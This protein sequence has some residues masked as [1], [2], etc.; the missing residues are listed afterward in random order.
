MNAPETLIVIPVVIVILYIYRN[1]RR[2]SQVSMTPG[3]A[4]LNAVESFLTSAGGISLGFSK[5]DFFAKNRLDKAQVGYSVDA[6]GK[7]LLT[8]NRPGSWQPAWL[9]IAKDHEGDPLFVQLLDKELPVYNASRSEGYWKPALLAISLD[10][11]V[12][13]TGRLH[14]A[15]AGRKTP[16]AIAKNPLPENESRDLLDNIQKTNPG[17]NMQYWNAFV[18]QEASPL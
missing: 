5:I 18:K 2:Y 15:S 4:E 16:G 11:F 6:N 8:N 14:K 3:D 1:R 7:N 10:N 13:I 9:V 17:V 12:E